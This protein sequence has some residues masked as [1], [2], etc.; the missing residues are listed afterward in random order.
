MN[1]PPGVVVRGPGEGRGPSGAERR[2]KVDAA[3]TGGAYSL[4]EG[5]LPA[6]SKGPP[7]HVHHRAEEAFYVL[8]GEATIQCGNQTVHAS[9]GSFVL[10]PRGVVHT[11]S[12]P[13]R[14]PNRLLIIFSPAGMEEYFVERDALGGTSADVIRAAFEGPAADPTL[15]AKF[16]AL[17]AKYDMD[18]RPLVGGDAA[19]AGASEPTSG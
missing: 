4:M 19:R 15:Q 1:R 6:G 12:N 10:I 14:T 16:T 8:E 18:R 5:A 2:I 7:P 3:A 13:G 17:S 11:H 9:A